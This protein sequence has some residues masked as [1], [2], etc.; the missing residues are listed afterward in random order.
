MTMRR[1][2]LCTALIALGVIV[3]ALGASAQGLEREPES[4]YKSYPV[5]LRF[6]SFLPPA[7]DLS[8]AFPQPGAQGPQASCTGWAV[9]YALRSYY[10][11]QRKGW[12]L[13]DRH[14]LFSP[15]FLYNQLAD[16]DTC[17]RGTA[18]SEAL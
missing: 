16:D 13:G 3:A 1:P 4:V 6:R 9:G 17:K 10:E 18:I 2:P 5:V 12:D 14:H 7:V 11:R 15:A 8:G